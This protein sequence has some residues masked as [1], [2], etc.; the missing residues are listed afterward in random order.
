MECC[1]ARLRPYEYRFFVRGDVYGP[2][3]AEL[4]V[5]LDE[6]IGTTNDDLVVDCCGLT[7]IDTSGLVVL[8]RTQQTLRELGR[9]LRIVNADDATERL[10]DLMG[11]AD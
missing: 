9:R 6:A 4:Q 7:S 3:A 1:Q 5:D 8:L 10:L 2:G 11:L